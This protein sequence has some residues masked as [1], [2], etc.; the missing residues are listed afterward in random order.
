MKKRKI[1]FQKIFC[2]TSFIFITTCILWYGGR[3]IYFYQD[4][5]KTEKVESNTLAQ[6]II[7]NNELKNINNYYYFQE[8]TTTNYIKYSNLLW[9]IIK[10]NNN[11]EIYL[12]TDN[13]I[14][15][16]A[17]STENYIAKWLNSSEELN[18]GILQKNL[19]DPSK[20]LTNYNVCNDTVDNITEI[21]CNNESNTQLI[22]LL[23]IIDYI[24]TGGEK[25]F[26]NNGQYTYLQNKNTNNNLWFINDK[27]KLGTN[28]SSEIYGIK[29]VIKLTANLDLVNGTGTIDDPYTIETETSLFAS[30][31]KLSNDI[32]RVYD[33]DGDN[34]KLVLNNYLKTNDQNVFTKYSN[35]TYYHNDTVFSSLAYYLNNTYLNNLSYKDIINTSYWANYYYGEDNNFNY[36]EVLTNQIDTKVSMLSIGDIVLNNNKNKGFFINTGTSNNSNM[37]YTIN[38]NGTLSRKNVTTNAYVIPTININKNILT[39]GN[40]TIEVPYEME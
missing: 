4:S 40:G 17:D 23:S 16:L 30:Y 37:I 9:R 34:I 7:K 29:P 21:T 11:N 19:N 25:S 14:T 24:N 32:W 26:I 15:H 5:K 2:F 3:F 20:Y 28:D 8:D 18:T 1:N 35:N 39:K 12:I 22:G 31:V 13:V 10:I 27:G 38:S 36:Q 33:I 6:I